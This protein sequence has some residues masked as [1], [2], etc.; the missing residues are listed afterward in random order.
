MV[1]TETDLILSTAYVKLDTWDFDITF[2]V[3]N[4]GAIQLALK[5]EPFAACD[6]NGS[7]SKVSS[8]ISFCVLCYN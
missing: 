4:E 7:I 8:L 2:P 6:K 3:H 5:I 1:I